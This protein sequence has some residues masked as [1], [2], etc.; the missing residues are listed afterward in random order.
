VQSTQ[1]LIITLTIKNK[2]SLNANYKPTSFITDLENNSL[3]YNND[4]LINQQIYQSN[5]KTK[6]DEVNLSLFYKREFEKPIQEL[7]I[8]TSA[9]LFNSKDRNKYLIQLQ[10]NND[11]TNFENII[12]DR[13]YISSK[14]DYV[15]PI[16]TKSQTR[17]RVPILLS[18]NELRLC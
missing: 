5:N 4:V 6:S 14:V 7:T 12:N 3:F 13:N 18:D 2:L 11:S 9:Y 17:G 10:A 1:V 16:G 15:H 8:E